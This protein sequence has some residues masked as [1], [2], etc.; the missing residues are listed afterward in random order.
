MNYSY[1]KTLKHSPDSVI[2][3]LCKGATLL[4]AGGKSWML[5]TSAGVERV[6]NYTGRYIAMM[7]DV[8]GIRMSK[9]SDGVYGYKMKDDAMI[10]LNEQF[11]LFM[12][13]QGVRYFEEP[14]FE[15]KVF[16]DP[17][18]GW[19]VAIYD[20]G[21][22]VGRMFYKYRKDLIQDMSVANIKIKNL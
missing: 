15:A 17:Y 6:N 4:Q 2:R 19:V 22:V 18:E 21:S 8:I 3:E 16:R 5:S 9:V 12:K 20:G 10:Y 1:T 7:S 14:E 13:L 11:R